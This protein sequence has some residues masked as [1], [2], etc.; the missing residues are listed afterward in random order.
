MLIAR[1]FTPARLPLGIPADLLPATVGLSARLRN[2]FSYCTQMEHW[3][4]GKELNATEGGFRFSSCG[5]IYPATTRFL[6][7]ARA[8]AIL[9][10]NTMNGQCFQNISVKKTCLQR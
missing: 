7:F 9:N 6:S 8:V 3:Q 2:L 10:R 4:S 5:P 1:L